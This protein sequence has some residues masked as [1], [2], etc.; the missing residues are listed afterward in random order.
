MSLSSKDKQFVGRD[1]PAAPVEVVRAEGSYLFGPNGEKWIDFVMGWNVGNIGWGVGEI[2]EKLRKFKGPSY[3]NP[4]YLY[5]PW[6]ELAEILAKIT[7]GRLQKSFRATGGT[8]A[9]EIALQAAIVH[10]KRTKFVSIEGSYH[11]HSIGAMSVG[12]SDFKK[13]WKN[14]LHDCYKINLPLDSKAGKEVERILSGGDVAAFIA[15]PI[16]C[17]L[18]VV[19]P[20]K[21]F[22]EIVSAACKKHETLLILDEVATGFGR[23]GKMFASEHYGL[24]PDIMTLGKAITGGYGGLGVAI[25]TEEV[26]KSMEFDFSFYSTFGWYPLGVEAALANIDYLL[27]HKGPIL[28]N[29]AEMSKFFEQR[30]KSMKFKH[31]AEVRVKGLAVGIEFKKAGY[32]IEIMNRCQEN[33]LLTSEL[34]PN[35]FTIFPALNIERKVAE[36]GLNIL[37]TCI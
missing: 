14:L 37:E 3:V 18:G 33:G 32:A 27:K 36:E 11:G 19:I 30:L 4:Y 31:P 8:E 20:D 25:M 6:A 1:V 28:S 7:P 17:N 12:M 5:K 22:F 9:V 2:E 26:A 21:E 34:G 23:T 15:E 35:I 13:H 16:I 24:E 29:V 10:T